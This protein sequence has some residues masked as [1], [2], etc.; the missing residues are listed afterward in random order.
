MSA[1]PHHTPVHTARLPHANSA[2]FTLVELLVAVVLALLVALAAAGALLVARQGFGQVDAA[3]QLRDN[4]RFAQA[5][6]ERITVQAG[7]Q[8]LLAATAAPGTAA[9]HAALDSNPPPAVFGINSAQ[10]TRTSQA[11]DSGSNRSSTAAGFGSDILV[12]RYQPSGIT[13]FDAR[14]DG[15]MVDCLGLSTS[16][17]LLDQQERMISI[18][19]VNVGSDQEPALMCTRSPDGITLQDTQPLVSGVELFQVLY[20]VDGIGPKNTAPPTPESADSVP[21]RYLRADELTINNNDSATYANWRRVRSLRIG[22]VLRGPAGSA[23]NTHTTGVALPSATLFPLGY[24]P[25]HPNDHGGSSALAHSQD[26]RAIYTP[27]D[28]GRLRQVVTFTIHL[29]NPQD[30]P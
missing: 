17:A 6:L 27:P 18:F 8:D 26:P 1:R 4:A 21:E 7:Y 3:A 12:L 25:Q 11:W 29:R 9:N 22:L 15:S 13:S 2:G 5:I 23:L 14:P 28:D 30:A 19:H 24:V 10:R 16:T 20:G